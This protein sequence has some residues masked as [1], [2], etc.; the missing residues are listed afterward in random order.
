MINT[1]HGQELGGWPIARRWYGIAIHNLKEAGAKRIFIDMAFVKA[2]IVHPESD[3][4]FYEQ[5]VRYPDVYL[6]TDPDI[7]MILGGKKIP[8]DRLYYPFSSGLKS[9]YN[10]IHYSYGLQTLPD[11]FVSN[12]PSN[13]I[14]ISFPQKAFTADYTLI[15][16]IRG[17]VSCKDQ[18]V[19]VYLDYPGVTSYIV[20]DNGLSMSTSEIQIQMIAA[21]ENQ[22]YKILWPDWKVFLCFTV[23]WIILGGWFFKKRMMVWG[24]LSVSAWLIITIFLHFTKIYFDVYWYAS[25]LP[26]IVFMLIPILHRRRKESSTVH[27]PSSVHSSTAEM[28]DLRYRLNY[29][30]QLS[31]QIPPLELDGT[32]ESSGIFYHRDSP[33][34]D[35]LKKSDQVAKSDLAVMI[36]GES[37]TGKEKLAQFIHQ[38]SERAGKPFIAVNCGSLNEN[39]IEAE[40]FGYEKGAFTGA[41]QQ[42]IGRFEA[43]DGGTL[44][45]DEV[46]ETSL[47][48][49]VKLLRVLQEGTFERV[50]GVKPIAVNVRIIAA[51]HQNIADAIAKG[52]FREDLFYRLNGFHFEIPPLRERRMDIELIFKQFL[53]ELD[54]SLQFSPALVEWLSGQMWRGNVRQ[55]RS[56]TQRAVINARMRQ[57]KF[58]IPEDFEITDSV[59]PTKE[60]GDILADQIL[61][62]FRKYEFKHRSISAVANDLDLHR[63]TV[64]EYL[65]GWVIRA[66]NENSGDLKKTMSY[67][68]G[69]ATADEKSLRQRVEEY[70][71]YIVQHISAGIE[72]NESDQVIRMRFKNLPKNFEADL[73]ALIEIER[74]K[75]R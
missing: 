2:D 69:D 11:F 38:R 39:L 1:I 50:G 31:Y 30:E 6:L 9:D 40:L 28:E 27:Q 52:K 25:F 22:D 57:R 14:V 16:A 26:G 42:K 70:N 75:I 41:V 65:R 74:K 46:A 37:G 20:G 35:I 67:L 44:F 24:V 5:L 68:K 66:R 73:A 32:C 64:T 19:M 60:N 8:A 61:Q 47:A 7:D 48:F 59:M 56:A 71:D 55:L 49:Q 62:A 58:V 13:R 17:E 45:L 3:E 43:A 36:I 21:I 29:Y 34:S 72:N 63:T 10:G 54:A 12:L 51:T 4:F 15:Q 53:Y 18:D 33:M 23:S